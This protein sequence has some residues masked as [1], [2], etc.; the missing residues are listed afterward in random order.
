MHDARVFANS[1]IFHKWENENRFQK[2]T[3][4]TVYLDKETILTVTLLAYPAYPIKPWV[5]KLSYIIPTEE[6]WLSPKQDLAIDLVG[7]EWKLKFLGVSLLLIVKF[8]NFIKYI[9]LSQAL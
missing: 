7:R 2:R 8:S 1:E 4:K 5:L 3:K 6:I 9:L